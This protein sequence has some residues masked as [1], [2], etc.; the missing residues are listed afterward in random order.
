MN[1][2]HHAAELQPGDRK[3]CAAIGV[4]DGVHL[5]HQQVLR[6]TLADARQ[7]EGLPVAITFDR[8]PASVLAPER[9]PQMIYRLEKKLATLGELGFEHIYLIHFDPEFSRLTGEEFIRGLVRDFGALASIC[10]GRNFTFGHRRSGNVA[11]LETLGAEHGFRVHGLAAVALDG[12]PVSSTRIRNAIAQGDLDAAGQMLGR[13]YTLCGP[14]VAG[15]RLGRRIG[16]P[17]ANIESTG[18]VTPP[19]GVYAARATLQGRSF[20]AAV[21]IGTRPT[22]EADRP[23][24]QVEAHLLDFDG[25]LYGRELELNFIERLRDEMKFPDLEA[26]KAQIR[27]DLAAARRAFE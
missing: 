6:Q 10:V 8:H 18:L 2:F 11:L 1:I 21:N 15:D 4:F 24:R 7:C 17:T 27:A 23:V 3:V 16:F 25:D 19:H 22:L 5:G 14:V 9:A 12:Q 13:A 26:L 20:R